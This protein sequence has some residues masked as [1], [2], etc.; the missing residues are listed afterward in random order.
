MSPSTDGPVRR[1]PGRRRRRGRPKLL[2]P[3]GLG[4][5]P[6]DGGAGLPHE[7]GQ[8]RAAAMEELFC[9]KKIKGEGN[10]SLRSCRHAEIVFFLRKGKQGTFWKLKQ[11]FNKEEDKRQA[12]KSKIKGNFNK[13]EGFF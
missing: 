2:L 13:K 12:E 4:A 10:D 5:E 9:R 11:N 7:H 6:G 3:H 1:P 8:V